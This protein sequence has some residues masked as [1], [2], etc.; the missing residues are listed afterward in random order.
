MNTVLE[1]LEKDNPRY[2]RLKENVIRGYIISCGNHNERVA[3]SAQG[4]IMQ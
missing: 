1:H 2:Y 3:L 4:G